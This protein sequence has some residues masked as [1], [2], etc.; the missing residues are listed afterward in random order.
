L[1]KYAT[2]QAADIAGIRDSR[3]K[4]L[5]LLDETQPSATTAQ[6]GE[7]T[8]LVKRLYVTG[9]KVVSRLGIEPRTRRLR[10]KSNDQKPSQIE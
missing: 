10:V 8:R 3:R 1:L 7:K 4:W 2:L 9:R 6:P 5:D